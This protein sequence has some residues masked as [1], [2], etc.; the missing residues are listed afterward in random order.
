MGL[1][2]HMAM[3]AKLEENLKMFLNGWYYRF[4]SYETVKKFK[5]Y[6][7]KI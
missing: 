1:V 7:V 3:I 6:K 5:K 2:G 4:C